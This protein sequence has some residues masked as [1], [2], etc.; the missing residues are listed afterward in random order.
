MAN[1]YDSKNQRQKQAA[2]PAVSHAFAGDE[3][4]FHKAGTP[5][6]GKV[7]CVGKHG[8]TVEHGGAQHKVKWEHIAGHKKR[9]VQRYKVVDQGHDGMIVEDATG[10]R[11]Y[12]AVPLEAR[13]ERLVL[14]GGVNSDKSKPRN[15]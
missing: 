11:R 10:R 12:V 2:T 6:A 1:F 7:V 5:V 13:A 8:C 4:Y 3:V 14:S 15:T 9:S